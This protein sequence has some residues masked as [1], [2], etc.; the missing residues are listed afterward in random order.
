MYAIKNLIKNMYI[1]MEKFSI[2]LHTWLSYLFAFS[3]GVNNASNNR[4]T[5]NTGKTIYDIETFFKNQTI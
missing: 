2:W 3:H 4:Y 5:L 1:N